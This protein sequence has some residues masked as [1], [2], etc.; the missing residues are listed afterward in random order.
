MKNVRAWIADG[1]RS[2]ALP[3]AAQQDFSKVEIKTTKLNATTYML[4]GAGGNIGLSVGEDAVF[5]IDDQYAPL[6]AEDH[7]GDREAH[8][9]AGEVR[10]QHPLALRPYRRQREPRQR[11]GADLSPTRTCASA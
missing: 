3:A 11:R 1:S 7:R 6:T 9:Q 10:A 5:L 2:L 8:R 4:T